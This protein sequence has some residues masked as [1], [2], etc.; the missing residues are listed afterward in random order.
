MRFSRLLRWTWAL[1]LSAPVLPSLIVTIV[2]V[3]SYAT[4]VIITT[5][6]LK[7]Q[8]DARQQYVGTVLAEIR[9]AQAKIVQDMQR[10]MSEYFASQRHAALT[11][12]NEQTYDRNLQIHHLK[13]FMLQADLRWAES[14]I[15]RMTRMND[16]QTYVQSLVNRKYEIQR[17]IEKLRRETISSRRPALP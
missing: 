11:L 6:V 14:E 15:F 8:Q 4:A 3:L 17:Q 16:A 1:V 5:F 7:D 12:H 9:E 10:D 2:I 13:L